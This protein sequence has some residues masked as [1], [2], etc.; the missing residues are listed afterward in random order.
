MSKNAFTLNNDHSLMVSMSGYIL[1]Y[2]ITLSVL[3]PE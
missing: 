1:E 3:Q 2:K